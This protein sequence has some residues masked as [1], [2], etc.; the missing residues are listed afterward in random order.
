MSK[1]MTKA[2]A[3]AEFREFVLPYVR[4]TYE[5]DGRVD[6]I[7]RREAWINYVDAL[8]KDGRITDKQAD[9]WTNPF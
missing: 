7:A 4:E 8:Y 6:V 3:L 1:K 2:E 5:Q 9:T